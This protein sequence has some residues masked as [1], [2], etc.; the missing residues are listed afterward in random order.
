MPLQ[1]STP[2]PAVLHDLLR[3]LDLETDT[4]VFLNFFRSDCPWC[5]SE[6]PQ[7]AQTYKRHHDLNIQVLGVAV[8]D[9]TP[10]TIEKFVADKQL[11]FP[12]VP[13]PDGALRS[14]F[15][16]ER[17]PTVV[18]IGATGLIECTFEGATE[19]LNGILEQAI[20]AAAHGTQMPEFHMTGNGC[21][22]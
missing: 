22:P 18:A 3:S 7:L 4:P 16:I 11:T 2:A 21:A 13:D 12:V 6:M 9:D 15:A 19:Q 10:E 20:F 1:P 17:V 5:Q 14:A 8:G